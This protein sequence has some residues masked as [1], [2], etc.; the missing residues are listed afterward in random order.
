MVVGDQ[1]DLGAYAPGLGSLSLLDAATAG[2][3]KE[4]NGV[5]IEDY[6]E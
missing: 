6:S 3:I 5:L 4:F 2:L 1:P